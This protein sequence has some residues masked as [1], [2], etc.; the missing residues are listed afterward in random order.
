M[1]GK[2][3]IIM[4]EELRE[5]M[6][7]LKISSAETYYHC[8][9]VKNL[10]CNMIRLMNSEGFTSYTTH[11]I[12]CICKGAILHDIGKLYIRN[13]ILT[14]ESRL[15]E[16]EMECMTDHPRLGF[17]AV[18]R[19]LAK[20]EYEII[21]N[22]CLYHHERI[23]GEGYEGIEELPLYVEVVAICDAYDALVSDRVYRDALDPDTALSFIE[24]G[25]CGAFNAETVAYLKKIAK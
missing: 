4:P 5:L 19:Y 20:D 18:E 17:E 15:T 11:E 9:H 23:D 13:A 25:K 8:I 7:E 14:K 22:I 21:K 16:E 1:E 24:T 12:N 2:S 3:V 6:D 10:V